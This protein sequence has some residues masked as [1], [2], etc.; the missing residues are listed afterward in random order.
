MRSTFKL[1]LATAAIFNASAVFG[2]EEALSEGS[3]QPQGISTHNTNPI[4]TEE[5]LSKDPDGSRERLIATAKNP[6]REFYL[7]QIAL[8]TLRA[9]F[10]HKTD[11]GAITL[12]MGLGDGLKPADRFWLSAC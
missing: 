8:D 10:G 6:Q 1:F 5:E 3:P 12:E 4:P 11:M 9:V 2:S 7:R